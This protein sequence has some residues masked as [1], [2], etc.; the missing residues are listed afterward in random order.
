MLIADHSTGTDCSVDIDDCVSNPCANQASC[1]DE[2]NGFSCQC[3][4][5]FN[6]VLCENNIDECSLQPCQNGATCL[7]GIAERTCVCDFGFEGD[8]CEVDLCT[9][10]QC[11]ENDNLCVAFDGNASVAEANQDRCGVFVSCA[12]V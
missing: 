4:E 8:S 3:L 12:E 2:V 7:D 11:D 6:G 9:P 10:E 1:V 5:G